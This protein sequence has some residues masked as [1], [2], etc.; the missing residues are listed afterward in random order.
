MLA[1]PSQPEQTSPCLNV[2][3]KELLVRQYMSRTPHQ[4]IT[5]T[6]NTQSSPDLIDIRLLVVLA[7]VRHPVDPGLSGRA[8]NRIATGFRPVRP[9]P[10]P[11]G[12]RYWPAAARKKDH[13]A[14]RPGQ[15]SVPQSRKNLRTDG[16]RRRGKT[17]GSRNDHCRPHCRIRTDHLQSPA[18]WPA[19]PC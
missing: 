19:P 9:S 1:P 3:N 2:P 6:V 8:G 10:V 16:Y 5:V 12:P 4:T 11:A 17:S 14:Y 18:H 15:Q 7:F 13:P